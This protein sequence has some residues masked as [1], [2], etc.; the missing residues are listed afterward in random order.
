MHVA[1][2]SSSEFIIAYF[3]KSGTVIPKY[4]FIQT[5]KYNSVLKLKT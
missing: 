1:R 3:E 5:R 2:N 4:D